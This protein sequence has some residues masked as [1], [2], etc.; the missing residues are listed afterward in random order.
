MGKTIELYLMDGTATG[1]WRAELVN[2]VIA[3]KI[4]RGD[5]RKCEKEIRTSDSN[6]D[7]EMTKD[8]SVDLQMLNKPGVYF[9]FGK[10][11][12]SDKPF[13]YVGEAEDVLVRLQQPHTFENDEK[14]YWTEAIVLFRPGRLLEKTDVKYLEHRF[15]KIASKAGRYIVK[16]GNT[17]TK[18]MVGMAAKD[19]LEQFISNSLLILPTLGHK[20][21][22]SLPLV[23]SNDADDLDGLFYFS[24]NEGKGGKATGRLSSDGFWVLKGSYINPDIAP[25]VSNGIRKSREQYA[26]I[27]GKDNILKENIVFGSPSYA[28]TFVCGKNSNGLA[29]W[30]NK[31]GKTLKEIDVAAKQSPKKAKPSTEESHETILYLSNSKASATGWISE[32]K[33]VVAKGSDFSPN[34]VSS[35]QPGVK[36]L[37]QSLVEEGKVK[38]NKFVED[39][40]FESASTAAGVVTGSSINGLIAWHD[41]DGVTLKI[42]NQQ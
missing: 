35:C 18:P 29:E 27:I 23:K 8:R 42:I 1:R 26:S 7:D 41:K 37:R 32:G 6:L 3:Y 19:A 20:V 40:A 5:I 36:K 11:D 30:K 12:E 33:L 34:E 13:V 39:V 24:R 21:L 17:P 28:S 16:N 2:W 15:Y 31:K 25:Y 9:L 22:E 14:A 4:P 38:D 10:D